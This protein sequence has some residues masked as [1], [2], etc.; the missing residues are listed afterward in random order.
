MKKI[1]VAVLGLGGMGQ[2]HV[3]SAKD[4]EFVD[5]IYGYEPDVERRDA[6]AK[7]LGITPMGLEEILANPSIEMVTIA[8]VNEA[9]KDLAE[10]ALKAGK[11]V[12]C[13]KPMGTTL[14][15]AKQIL[16]AKNKYNGFLQIG[17][18]LHYSDMYTTVKKWID[19]GLVGDVVNAQFRYY[20]CEF[21]GRDSWRSRGTGSY[22]IGEKLSH[23]IDLQRWY[24]S[25]KETPVSVYSLSAPKVVNYF[26]HRDNHQILMKFSN[27]GV[28]T[29]NFIMYIAE[30]YH[31]KEGEEIIQKQSDD[32]HY[33]QLHL[34]G[35]KG[36]IEADVFK[37]RIRRWEFTDEP[38]G[39]E[40]KIVDVIKFGPEDDN[41]Y[42]HNTHDQNLRVFELVAK[43]LKPD[44][45]AEDAYDTMRLCFAAERSEDTGR[46]VMMDEI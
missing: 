20:C 27:G 9:H 33:L 17:F 28:A 36:A 29:M 31:P 6:R 8:A 35:T 7:E 1:N 22:L 19:E 13:E 15:E 32:G 11:A 26:G 41:R 23:Y 30:S 37:R 42:F 25:A 2:T 16:D 38:R 44:V 24:F 12:M 14:A 18:E 45:P 46:I 5:R 4:S 34:C 40:S 43:G 3:E 10:A 39:L 21:H